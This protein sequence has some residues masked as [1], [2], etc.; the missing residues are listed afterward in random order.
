MFF[1]LELS[2]GTTLQG[3]GS[4]VDAVLEVEASRLTPLLAVPL[5]V[6]AFASWRQVGVSQ[7]TGTFLGGP[8][9]KDYSILGSILGSPHFGKLPG[10]SNLFDV[11]GR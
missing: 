11:N 7:I 4:E 1:W 9:N 2:V 5:A 6:T 8:H 3:L 10:D